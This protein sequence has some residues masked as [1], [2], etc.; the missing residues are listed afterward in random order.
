MG[1]AHIDAS[2]FAQWRR[3]LAAT[4]LAEQPSRAGETA[5][6]HTDAADGVDLSAFVRM[7]ERLGARADEPGLSWSMGQEADYATRGDVGRA[8]LGAPTLGAAFR[9]LSEYFPLIQDA[10]DLR[11]EAGPRWAILS[12]RI[13][14]HEIWPRHHDAMYSLGIYAAMV[15]AAAPEAWR[16]VE[17]TVEAEPHAAKCDV[18]RIVRAN[19]A[20][21]GDANMLRFPVG[22]LDRP[23]T[24]ARP[25]ETS[26]ITG[27]T[28]ALVDKRRRSSLAARVRHA[29]FR[30]MSDGMVGQEHIA[31]ELGMSSRTLR[32][33]LTADGKSFQGVL[34]DCRMRVA[35][36]EFRSRPGLSL[37]ELALRLG[38]SEHSTFS[39]AF[40]R[41][42]G[43]A[44]QEF[45]R[46]CTLH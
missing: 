27:L 13:L 2:V 23:L 37:S 19:V 21:G 14:D 26:A 18:S 10:T 45:R 34:D 16:E 3:V 4:D 5:A 11:L 12:Y 41:W 7:L 40:A 24:L 46:S 36:L 32:R 30:E 35:A 33:K 31:R 28:R 1:E 38:Y 44:P 39:R 42:A 8:V 25:V 17:I 29:I 22:L 6:P 20:Y 43:M 15:K 9:R